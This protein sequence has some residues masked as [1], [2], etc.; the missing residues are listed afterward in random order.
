V[1]GRADELL[2]AQAVKSR[3]VE[4]I[5]YTPVVSGQSYNGRVEFLAPARFPRTLSVSRIQ[6]ET[7][8]Q[9]KVPGQWSND[10]SIGEPVQD[11]LRPELRSVNNP[12]TLKRWSSFARR[13]LLWN[14]LEARLTLSLHGAP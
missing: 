14:I 7:P 4:S 6:N 13:R 1:T 12:G 5:R 9:R 2:K 3:E 10:R 11:R 8:G